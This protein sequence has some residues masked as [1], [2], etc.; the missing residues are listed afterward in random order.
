[1]NIQKYFKF[2]DTD[3]IFYFFSSYY[4]FVEI[5]LLP[6]RLFLD[7]LSVPL[8]YMLISLFSLWDNGFFPA[9]PFGSD[10]RLPEHD[11]YGTLK[12]IR[13][14]SFS[15]VCFHF[16]RYLHLP[17]IFLLCVTRVGESFGLIVRLSCQKHRCILSFSKEEGP[18]LV[19]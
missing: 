14:P 19:V 1:M 10:H 16:W 4:I 11:L 3:P 13:G 5:P 7:P 8:T 9:D 17:A 18:L 12:K 6:T 2:S 15:F